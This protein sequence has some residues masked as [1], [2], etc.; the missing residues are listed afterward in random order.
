MIN[1]RTQLGVASIMDIFIVETTVQREPIM[2]LI[3]MQQGQ[4]CHQSLPNYLNK[5]KQQRYLVITRKIIEGYSSIL[6]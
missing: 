2:G 3:K 5:F 1:M 6:F 4:L